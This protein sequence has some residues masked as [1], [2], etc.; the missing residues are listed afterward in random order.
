MMRHNLNG[1]L[2]FIASLVVI[3]AGVFFSCPAGAQNERVK[4]Q[5]TFI[6]LLVALG[7]NQCAPCKMMAPAL[8]ELK[9]DYNGN[10][11]VE[12]IDIREK[13]E[14]IK[15]YDIPGIPFQ[16]FYGASGKE[17]KRHYGYMSK[18]EIVRILREMGIEPKPN[19][20]ELKSERE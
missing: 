2:V 6:P 16:I 4:K 5:P 10:L 1:R 9:R 13:P 18:G 19:P 8:E 7:R 20:A 17:F 3:L 11:R 12:F 15:K 14:A